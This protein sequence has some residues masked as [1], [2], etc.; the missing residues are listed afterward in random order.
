[1]SYF[2]VAVLNFIKCPAAFSYV[3]RA[4]ASDEVR[5]Y[6]SGALN[7]MLHSFDLLKL[8]IKAL[9]N[10]IKCPAAFSSVEGTYASNGV[11]FYICLILLSVLLPSHLLKELMLP[12]KYGFIFA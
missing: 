6:A 10:F 7:I 5:F 4:D 9:L 12:M 8:C 2:C 11:R 1:M 3:E